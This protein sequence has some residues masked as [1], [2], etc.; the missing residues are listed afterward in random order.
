VAILKINCRDCNREERVIVNALTHDEFLGCVE[1]P[2]QDEYA[3]DEWASITSYLSGEE[4][5][6]LRERLC[7]ACQGDTVDWY[8]LPTWVKSGSINLWDLETAKAIRWTA[9]TDHEVFKAFTTT[10]RQVGTF[11]RE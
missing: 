1:G 6:T 8:D 11:N 4:V 7:A 2:G 10:G 3:E 5:A 9:D